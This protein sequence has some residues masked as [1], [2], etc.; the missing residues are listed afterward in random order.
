M[1]NDYFALPARFI[2]RRYGKLFK[3]NIRANE[4]MDRI[5]DQRGYDFVQENVTLPSELE[6]LVCAGLRPEKDCILFKEIE[7]F[8]AGVIDSDF[9]KTEYEDFENH[10]HIDD[11]TF[12][13]TGEFEYLM[14]GLE[15]AKRI[16]KKLSEA[17]P[18]QFR[19]TVSFSE[20][21]YAGQ[22]IDTYGSC[23]VRFYMIRPGC[24]AKFRVDDLDKYETE[25]VL[26]IE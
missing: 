2:Y 21:T 3:M 16:Y 20:T 5:L 1:I 11:Y 6:K 14:L 13:V 26:V 23:I 9:K 7:Y 12:D 24:D 17:H 8:R 18:N 10:I 19:I 25:G 4:I 15:F 22:E